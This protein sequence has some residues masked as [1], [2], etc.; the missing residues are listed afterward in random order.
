L[1]KRIRITLVVFIAISACIACSKYIHTKDKTDAYVPF[2]QA[3]VIGNVQGDNNDFKFTGEVHSKREVQIGFQIGGRIIKRNINLGDTINTGDILFQIDPADARQA[4]ATTQAQLSAARSQYVLLQDNVRRYR[5]LYENGIISKVEFDQR[6]TS[7]DLAQAQ[8]RQASA[9][10]RIGSNQ[11]EYCQLKASGRGVVT[12][13]YAEQGQMVG[14]G[15]PVMAMADPYQTEIAVD[16][17]ESRLNELD[18]N[19]S[20]MVTFWALP[21]VIIK[22]NVSEVSPMADVVTR[23]YKVK[24]SLSQQPAKVK[25]GMTATVSFKSKLASD[26]IMVPISAVYQFNDNNYLWLVKSERVELVPV[27]LGDPV[28]D[29]MIQIT[30]GIKSGDTV[31]TAGVHKLRNHQKVKAKV[32]AL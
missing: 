15:Q 26:F 23:S 14:A 21:G 32:D 25:L 18:V 12:A 19:A 27:T 2:V 28:G 20:C 16:V 29:N 4:M 8:M 10:S 6:Q 7:L 13:I 11:L 5:K 17:P 24:V 31:V 30:A 3:Q 22:G 1:N 9:Q